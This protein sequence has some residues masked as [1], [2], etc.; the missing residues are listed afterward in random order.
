MV[1]TLHDHMITS[2]RPFFFAICISFISLAK[3]EHK[4]NYMVVPID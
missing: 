4:G 2:R 3:S 1:V